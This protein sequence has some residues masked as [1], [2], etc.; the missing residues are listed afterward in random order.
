MS[1]TALSQP[2]PA[3]PAAPAGAPPPFGRTWGSD[4]RAVLEGLKR[5]IAE[6]EERAW[7]PLS[8]AEPPWTTGDARIDRALGRPLPARGLMEL[9]GAGFADGP[10][11]LGLALAL[12]SRLPAAEDGRRDILWC[13]PSGH[14]SECGTPYGPGL[15]AAGIDP[16]R[17]VVAAPKKSA[18][19]L[20]AME[21]GLRSGAFRAVLGAAPETGIVESRRLALSARELATPLLLMT[22]SEST[23]AVSAAARW[24]V[25]S[26]LAATDPYD[27]RSPDRPRIEARL[28]RWPGRP[29]ATFLIDLPHGEPDAEDPAAA[30]R[31]R[32]VSELPDRAAST[33]Q[34]SEGD[35]PFGQLLTFKRCP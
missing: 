11:A 2:D 12:L 9:K 6:A 18:H 8:R 35:G 10:A 28:E 29:P 32:L 25:K 19:A 26:A 34:P 1:A 16:A 13:A 31:L 27:P 4:R 24:R 23:T 22:G 15:Q 17:L 30:R 20:W 5:R 7:T 3:E 21:E 33:R 14:F